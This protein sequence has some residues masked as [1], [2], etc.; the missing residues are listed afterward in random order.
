MR[1]IKL[2][3]HCGSSRGGSEILPYNVLILKG[4][5]RGRRNGKDTLEGIST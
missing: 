2:I 5:Q 1:Q 3:L 4:L